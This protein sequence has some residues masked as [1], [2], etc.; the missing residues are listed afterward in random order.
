MEPVNEPLQQNQSL[1][2]NASLTVINITLLCN[3]FF[4]EFVAPVLFYFSVEI[5]ICAS[6]WLLHFWLCYQELTRCSIYY[7]Q[8]QE[9]NIYWEQF[10]L[11]PHFICKLYILYIQQIG[12]IIGC[13]G[14][15][16]ATHYC[17]SIVIRGMTLLG[18]GGI[19]L[20]SKTYILR[21]LNYIYSWNLVGRCLSRLWSGGIVR[22]TVRWTV[23]LGCV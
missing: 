15:G 19:I 23:R 16:R 12:V 14:L 8:C 1:R 21:L 3:A 9:Q 6:N 18:R 13:Y 5:Y 11:K 4:G 7:Q 2:V 20:I 10:F 22:W 17:P